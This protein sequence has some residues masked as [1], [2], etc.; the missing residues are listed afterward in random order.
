MVSP[1]K[2]LLI[3]KIPLFPLFS[4][5]DCHSF[6]STIIVLIVGLISSLRVLS[7]S[8]IV[9]SSLKLMPEFVSDSSYV[10]PLATA[11]GESP[12]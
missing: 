10:C 11:A 1:L 7:M 3:S 5:F 4:L 9:F 6:V 8:G 12:R 2:L